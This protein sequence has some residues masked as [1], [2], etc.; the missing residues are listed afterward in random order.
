MYDA[1]KIAVLYREGVM[2]DKKSGG[3]K[4][5]IVDD[6]QTIR[7]LVKRM[8]GSNY[9]VLE[10]KDG[11]EAID[12]TLSQKPDLVIMDIM[13]PR[14]DGITALNELKS[15][16]STRKIPVIMLTGVDYAL[17]KELTERMGAAKYVTKPIRPQDLINVIN[18]VLGHPG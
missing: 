18:Q 11:Q 5:M 14:K 6:E 2:T 12:L 15:N 4:I 9:T 10:A 17:N 1:N 7:L 13:M 8:L 16:Q 3:K